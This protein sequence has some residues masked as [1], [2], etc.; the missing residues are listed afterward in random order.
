MARTINSAII[1]ASSRSVVP[2]QHVVIFLNLSDSLPRFGFE[3]LLRRQPLTDM[4]AEAAPSPLAILWTAAL[5]SDPPDDD[6][7]VIAQPVEIRRIVVLID[8]RAAP[9]VEGLVSNG[10]ILQQIRR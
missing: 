10:H 8:L 3:T 9:C 2:H 1:L 7:T 4:R 6:F 5:H